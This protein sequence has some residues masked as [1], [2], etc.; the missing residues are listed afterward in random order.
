YHVSWI[1]DEFGIDPDDDNVDVFVE[2]DSGDRYVATFF[3]LDNLR[4]L[5]ENYRETGECANGLYVWSTHMIV[6]ERLTKANVERA[7]ADLIDSGEF[8]TAFERTLDSAP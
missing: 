7:I 4:S 6:I 8:S 1:E 3:A 2:F 5:M